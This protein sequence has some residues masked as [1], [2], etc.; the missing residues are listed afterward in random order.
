MLTAVQE[1]EMSSCRRKMLPR[2]NDRRVERAELLRRVRAREVDPVELL[3][4]PPEC[5][6]SMFVFDFLRQIPRV[7]PGTIRDINYA[8]IL[9]RVNLA[10]SVGELGQTRAQWL[11]VRLER[12]RPHP[13]IS[14][15]PQG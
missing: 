4:N 12:R 7:G 14:C 5:L 13:V 3:L 11:A 8:A 9:A 2:A 10:V 15:R 6:R 1:S